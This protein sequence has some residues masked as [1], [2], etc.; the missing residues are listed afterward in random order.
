MCGTVDADCNVV[1]RRRRSEAT[2]PPSIARPASPPWA[3]RASSSRRRRRSAS[4]APPTSEQVRACLVSVNPAE[5]NQQVPSNYSRR[6]ACYLWYY[7]TLRDVTGQCEPDR[8]SPPRDGSRTLR[9]TPS[10]EGS[11]RHPPPPPPRR[12]ESFQHSGNCLKYFLTSVNVFLHVL[13]YDP[14]SDQCK[15]VNTCTG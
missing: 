14:S 11:E 12:K 15:I 5:L 1:L 4:T 3:Q 10:V 7:A 6:I 13:L 9:A 2:P 8:P